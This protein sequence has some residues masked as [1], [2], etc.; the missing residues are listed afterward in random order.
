[1]PFRCP[2]GRTECTPYPPSWLI[3]RDAIYPK[4]VGPRAAAQILHLTP[5]P[6]RGLDIAD[7]GFSIPRAGTMILA[8]ILG[9]DAL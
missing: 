5:L 7:L 1:M 9:D 3:S 4:G 8:H 2:L 6:L